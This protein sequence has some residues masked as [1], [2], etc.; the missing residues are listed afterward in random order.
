MDA[1]VSVLLFVYMLI[2][3]GMLASFILFP[4]GKKSQGNKSMKNA[5]AISAIE[6]VVL[7]F[8]LSVALV[9]L[10][11]F[12][13]YLLGFEMSEKNTLFSVTCLTVLFLIY[14][15]VRRFSFKKDT[16]LQ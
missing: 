4:N 11:V 14:L 7:S 9:P 15:T 10:L 1:V 13:M 6:R 16:N 5:G 12:L 3:P 8:S 2:V